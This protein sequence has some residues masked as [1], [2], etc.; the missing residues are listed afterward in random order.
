MT[1]YSIS[2]GHNIQV[3]I[4]KTDT[5]TGL[6]AVSQAA[7][8]LEVPGISLL[9]RCS[10]IGYHSLLSLVCLLLE[11]SQLLFLLVREW[12]RKQIITFLRRE[13]KYL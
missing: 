10:A 6:E 8:V 5:H 11:D 9:Y 3:I 4:K 12:H 7:L 13:H 1:A 2:E